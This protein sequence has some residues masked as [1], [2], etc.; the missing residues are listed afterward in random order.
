MSNCLPQ[1]QEACRRAGVRSL[2][3]FGSAASGT[4]N[5]DSSDID[6]LV[7]MTPKAP[8]LAERFLQL[9]RD[10]SRILGRQ[11]D[12][13]SLHGVRNPHFRAELESTRLPIYAAA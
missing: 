2:W 8:D 9:Y 7:E 11:I 6:L 13:V 10:L 4:W 5:P 1:I 12:L 3:A